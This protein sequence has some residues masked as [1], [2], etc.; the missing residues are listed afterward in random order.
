LDYATKTGPVE[1]KRDPNCS[2]SQVEIKHE[3]DL[4][5][6]ELMKQQLELIEEQKKV[7]EMLQRQEEMLHEK[8]VS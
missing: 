8:Q 6:I 7:K 1:A 2:S 4:R 5:K 3:Q